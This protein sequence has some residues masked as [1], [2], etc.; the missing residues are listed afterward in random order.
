MLCALAHVV[1]VAG[2]E[3]HQPVTMVRITSTVVILVAT[4]P[5]FPIALEEALRV[6]VHVPVLL[7]VESERAPI[8][9]ENRQDAKTREYLLVQAPV[10]IWMRKSKARNINNF[11]KRT[12]KM[13]QKVKSAA[14]VSVP[15]RRIHPNPPITTYRSCAK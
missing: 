4:A 12:M 15:V 3:V 7:Q 14:K 13:I 9:V 10:S 1:A 2:P 8:R 11:L 5:Q 6:Q